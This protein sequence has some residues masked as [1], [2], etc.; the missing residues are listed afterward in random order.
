MVIR[1][2]GLELALPEDWTV[3]PGAGPGV[4]VGFP[5]QFAGWDTSEIPLSLLVQRIE[6]EGSME[7]TVARLMKRRVAQ[8]VPE[9]IVLSL[10]DRKTI[11]YDWTDGVA[12]VISC[13]VQ[14]N[15]QTAYEFQVA[16]AAFWGAERLGNDARVP[17]TDLARSL[18]SETRWRR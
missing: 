9:G 2:L 7:V 17:L 18:L 1:E 12:E 15:L 16:R 8:G 4:V 5:Q 10:G 3:A 6:L 14:A 11:A 13:F